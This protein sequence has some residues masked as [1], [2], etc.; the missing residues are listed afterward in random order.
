M[1]LLALGHIVHEGLHGAGVVDQRLYGHPLLAAADAQIHVAHVIPNEPRGPL[2]RGGD[3]VKGLAEAALFQIVQRQITGHAD[4]RRLKLVGNVLKKLKG[5]DEERK[6]G[7]RKGRK[8][9]GNEDI[10]NKMS[11]L[12]E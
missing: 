3:R 6:K 1:E 8:G 11:A 12:R 2:G 7:E 9:N 10:D 5:S 4:V